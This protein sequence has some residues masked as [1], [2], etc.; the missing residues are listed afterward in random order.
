MNWCYI[1]KGCLPQEK[2]SNRSIAAYCRRESR[3]R[4]TRT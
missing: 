2:S 1:Y 4:R 3:K